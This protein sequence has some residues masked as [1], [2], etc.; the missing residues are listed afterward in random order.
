MNPNMTTTFKEYD[1][2]QA[3]DRSPIEG[4]LERLHEAQERAEKA[5]AILADRVRAVTQPEE[6]AEGLAAIAGEKS[7][8]PQSPVLSRINSAAEDLLRLADRMQ[9]LTD[10]IDT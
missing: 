5:F 2:Q 7:G 10:R 8:F 9:R 6:P 4:G 3:A 1:A